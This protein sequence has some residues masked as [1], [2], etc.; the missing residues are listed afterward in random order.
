MSLSTSL[1]IAVEALNAATG[2]LQITNNN[3]ANANTTGYTREKVILQ[4]SATT[5]TNGV[6]LGNGVS[7]EGYQSVRN[8]LLQTRV[9]QET[10]AQSGASAQLSSLQAIEPTF[11]TSTSDIGTEMSALFSSISSL[12]TDP[13]SSTLQETVLAAGQK[14]ATAFNTASSTL[15]SQQTGLNTQVTQD[16]SEINQLSKQIAALNPQIVNLKASGQ[17][18]GGTLQD[19]QDA[20]VLKLSALTNVSITQT[21][22]GE[23]LTTGNGAPLVVGS[24][25]YDL[26]TTTGTDGMQHVLDQN[27]NDITSSL[28]SGDLGGTIQTR[29]TTIPGL[30]TQLDTLANQFATAINSAQASGY[31]ENG[32]AGTDFFTAS[33]SAASIT[34]S[35]ITMAITDPAKIAS[36]SD[37]TSGSNGNLA[38]LSAVQTTQLASGQTPGDAYAGLVYQVGSLTASANAESTASTATLLQLNDQ[39]SSVS[40]VSTDE[41]AANLIQYQQAYEAAARVVSTIQSLFSI[42]MTMGTAA[43]E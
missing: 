24:Q 25:S 9:E 8:E 22:N 4:E 7:L 21:D 16:V 42:T 18:D 30:L 1:N 27:G 12:S 20:L 15:T 23:T 14:L 26:Q 35:S 17:Q 43:A 38:N 5:T 29:D 31:D 37:G 34:A 2:A 41:E 13:T 32:K 11:T 36:S 6:S 40:G 10:Q 28:T 3:I 39:L 19:Q 33:G